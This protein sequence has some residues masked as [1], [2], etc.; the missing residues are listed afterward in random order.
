MKHFRFEAQPSLV[1]IKYFS[2]TKKLKTYVRFAVKYIYFFGAG[3]AEGDGKMKDVLGGKG[4]G[5]AE[6]TRVQLPGSRRVHHHHRMLR[7][8]PQA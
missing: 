6:M 3:K 1:A 8:L 5:L 7:L 4:A 2:E